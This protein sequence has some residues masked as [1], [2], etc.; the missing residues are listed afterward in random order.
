MCRK[1]YEQNDAFVILPSAGR[2][3]NSRW[4]A[5]AAISVMELEAGSGVYTTSTCDYDGGVNDEEDE[6]ERK[7]KSQSRKDRLPSQH[8]STHIVKPAMFMSTIRKTNMLIA[9]GQTGVC[10]QD[11]W[12]L[13][14]HVIALPTCVCRVS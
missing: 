12:C 14:G 2:I 10:D 8:S 11:M 3:M 4:E 13:A 5:T 6:H 1:K 9:K 7:R